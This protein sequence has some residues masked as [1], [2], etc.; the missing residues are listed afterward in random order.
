M[1]KV[2]GAASHC[3]IQL[4]TTPPRPSLRRHPLIWLALASLLLTFWY[5]VVQPY[6]AR[7]F[8]DQSPTNTPT[9]VPTNTPVFTATPIPTDTPPPFPTDTPPVLLTD[10]PPALP[11][12]TTPVPLTDTPP[13]FPTLPP[14]V[15]DTPLPPE[16]TLPP[17][18][19]AV[20]ATTI[21]SPPPPAAQPLTTTT[22]VI[23][24]TAIT[25]TL[26]PASNSDALVEL[27]DAFIL[28]SAY[29]LLGCG[30]IVFIALA[31][32]FYLL[33]R[34]ARSIDDTTP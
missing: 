28:Y 4:M 7:A 23:S 21:P 12:D 30:V 33:H 1:A 32:G 10:T 22:G 15:A 2:T 3:I 11:A 24:T 20:T 17:L 26:A 9:L 34:R 29:F 19:P 18:A 8:Q 31:V 5:G 16:P 6:G 13:V 27:I 25:T 14:E